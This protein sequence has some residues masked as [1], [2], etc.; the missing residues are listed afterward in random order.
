MVAL[1]AACGTLRPA[2]DDDAVVAD[3]GTTAAEAGADAEPPPPGKSFCATLTDN[4]AFCEDFEEP[5]GV[6]IGAEWDKHAGALSLVTVDEAHGRSLHASGDANTNLRKKLSVPMGIRVELDVR[7]SALPSG[8]AKVVSLQLVGTGQPIGFYAASDLSYFQE[9]PKTIGADNTRPLGSDWHHVSLDLDL[10]HTPQ[11]LSGSV[12]S[13]PLANATPFDSGW[14]AGN[15]VELVV[16]IAD[17]YIAS[18]GDVIVDN[19]VAYIR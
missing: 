1:V 7:Y 12:D 18:M 17:L 4:P 2:P 11:L 3:G 5:N 13:Q 10:A 6:M 15:Q 16:G 8:D 9:D 14:P 19:I